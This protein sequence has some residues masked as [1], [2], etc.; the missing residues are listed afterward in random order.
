MPAKSA[1]QIIHERNNPPKEPFVASQYKYT[2]MAR[3]GGSFQPWMRIFE[4]NGKHYLTNSSGIEDS[5]IEHGLTH[6]YQPG[7]D[8]RLMKVD[9]VK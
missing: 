2:I 6:Y 3:F 9:V 5:I 4:V 1:S 7:P 8:G